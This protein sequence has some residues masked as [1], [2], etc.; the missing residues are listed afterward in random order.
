VEQ[1]TLSRDI[2]TFCCCCARR[3][4]NM[5]VL[6]SYA[7]GTPILIAGPCWPFCVFV[8]LPLIMGVAGLVS[9]FLIFD[10][11]F[12]LVSFIYF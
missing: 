4:G 6:C 3:I 7:D 5:F 1:G 11:R 10:D 2:N 8:T 9:F 12:G